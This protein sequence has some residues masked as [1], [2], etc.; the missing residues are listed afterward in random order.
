MDWTMFNWVDWVLVAVLLYGAAMGAVRGLS[1]E[2]AT[3]IGI[4]AAV[5]VTRLFYEPAAAWICERWDWNPEVTRLA[6]V[7]ALALATLLGMRLLRITLGALMTFSFQGLVER[8][9]GLVAGFFRLGV[10]FLGLMLAGYFVPSARLQRAVQD[11]ATGQILLPHLVAGYN[12][13]AE[14]ANLIE[15]EIPVGVELPRLV[16]PPGA[17]E[18]E[19]PPLP[20]EFAE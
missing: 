18:A 2:L 5:I 6:A 4:A 9:G 19:Y 14:K 12:A 3:L 8:L 10:I 7:V 13:L 17:D 1:H 16:M 20:A 11:S 15:A